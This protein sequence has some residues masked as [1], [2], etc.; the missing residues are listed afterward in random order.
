MENKDKK[1]QQIKTAVSRH[2]SEAITGADTSP[3]SLLTQAKGVGYTPEQLRSLPANLSVATF[4]CGNPVDFLPVSSGQTVLDLGSGAGLDLLLAAQKVG[5]QGKVI[6]VDMTPAMLDKARENIA[7]AGAVNIEIRRGEMENL[8]VADASID[9]V[10]SNCVINLSP[11][12]EK[13]FAEIA[14]VLKPGGGMVVSD[15][16]T[17]GTIPD[18]AKEDLRVWAGC[19]GGALPEADYL[20]C[21]VGAGLEDVRVTARMI[22]SRSQLGSFFSGCCSCGTGAV[23]GNILEALDGKIASVK[24]A[25]RKPEGDSRQA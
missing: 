18:E 20:A 13:V 17:L 6:G 12:K 1:D 21:A 19:V 25:A 23:A 11:D 22:Y 15:I 2:Y 5:P 7:R 3:E 14:R 16:V 10:I 24:V 9:W 4:G 8:P